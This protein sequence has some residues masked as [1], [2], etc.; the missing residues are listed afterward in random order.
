MLGVDYAPHS[1]MLPTTYV[2]AAVARHLCTSNVHPDSVMAFVA[3]RLIPLNKNPGVR[4][5][6]ISEVPRRIITKAIVNNW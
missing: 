3:C 2:M 5:I 1:R 4:P 6:G